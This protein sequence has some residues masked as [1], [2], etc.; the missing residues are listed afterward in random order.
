MNLLHLK[1]AVEVAKTR[2]ISRAAENLYMGQPNLSRAIKELEADLGIAIFK[3]TTKGI[4]ITP[5][6][7]K[8]LELAR[9]VVYQVEEIENI[10]KEERRGK[11]RFSACVP[12][13]SYISHAMAEL[14]ASL[15]T[16]S[17]AEIYYKETNS[18]TAIENV[19]GG[20]FDLGIIRYQ[21][22]YGKYFDA[23]FQEKH[24]KAETLTEFTYV[25]LMSEKS[26]LSSLPEV[27]LSDLEDF[28]EISH[29]DPYVPSMQMIDVRKD[30]LTQ[31]VDK[32]IFVFE[33][34]SQFEI[35]ERVPNSFMWVSP[36][37]P[38]LCSKY[39]LVQKT[40]KENTKRYKDVLIYREDYRLSELDN[41]FLEEVSSSAG[42]YIL[43][44]ERL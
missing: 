41:R 35:L 20:M 42:K 9:G 17:P 15:R 12:R 10:Y 6:G 30:E 43:G 22:K 21:L 16:D 19:S 32:H 33:R 2:S 44:L 37:S 7:E 5:E 14:A 31:P 18:S 24:L 1:Y 8:F 28:I 25:L 40:C 23:I 29:S 38:E 3:R 26:R 13:A 11:Q 36:V 27:K 34:S 4:S 39:G